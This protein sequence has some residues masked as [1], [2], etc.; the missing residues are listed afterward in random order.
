MKTI[1]EIKD[2]LSWEQS[3]DSRANV[4]ISY[5]G[6]KTKPNLINASEADIG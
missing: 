5:L 1:K 3:H 2:S 6:H 4:C